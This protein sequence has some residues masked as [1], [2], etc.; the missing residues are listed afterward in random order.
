MGFKLQNSLQLIVKT[1][2]IDFILFI[3]DLIDTI[4]EFFLSKTEKEYRIKK[5]SSLVSTIIVFFF[6]N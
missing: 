1:I 6:L 2:F 3:I 5:K 4:P